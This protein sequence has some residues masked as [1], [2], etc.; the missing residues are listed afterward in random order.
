ML[1]TQRTG[2]NT[3]FNQLPT[4]EANA[5][6]AQNQFNLGRYGTD[7]GVYGTNV[8]TAKDL[9]MPQIKSDVETNSPVVQEQLRQG[10]QK[11]GIQQQNA[12]TARAGAAGNIIA[13]GMFNPEGFSAATQT[14]P[15]IRNILGQP[16]ADTSNNL[17]GLTPQQGNSPQMFKF[18]DLFRTDD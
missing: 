5:V 16:T 11:I 17:F 15:S 13:N 3:Y 18:M 14:V 7:A 6:N 12:D 4:T 9:I 10:Q 2:L 1:N 8:T